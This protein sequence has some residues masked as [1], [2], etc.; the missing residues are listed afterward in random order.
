M[1]SHTKLAQQSMLRAYQLD[2]F[3][4][5]LSDTITL[6]NRLKKG[7]DPNMGYRGYTR[8]TRAIRLEKEDQRNQFVTILLKHNA[9]PTKED[10]YKNLPLHTAITHGYITT[11]KILLSLSK[12]K[13]M[14][15]QKESKNGYTPLHIAAVCNIPEVVSLLLEKGADYQILHNQ[16][17][18]TAYG[19]A[20]TLTKQ[21]ED[22]SK[23]TKAFD[24]Y[25]EN[26][27]K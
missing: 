17:K 4:A 19:L 15:D 24:L 20:Q 12:K 9:D 21:G 22:R 18:L 16:T 7:E 25:F 1:D 5:L 23:F 2:T 3:K 8:L 13:E 27:L 6:E 26:K 14:L 11:V 10:Q